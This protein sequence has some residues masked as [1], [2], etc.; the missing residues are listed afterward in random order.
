MDGEATDGQASSFGSYGLVRDAEPLSLQNHCRTVFIII[1]I[2]ISMNGWSSVGRK[3][4]IV[5]R[6]YSHTIRF[7]VLRR[8][9]AD[10]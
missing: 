4:F 1:I 5:L 6:G 8:I 10:C 7:G 2:V 3:S 9:E